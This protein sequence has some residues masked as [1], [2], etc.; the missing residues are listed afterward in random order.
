[1]RGRTGNDSLSGQF[2]ADTATFSLSA[3]AVNVN[4][5]TNVA[6]GEGSDILNTAENVVG[7]PRNDTLVGNSGAN[8][9]DGLAGNDRIDARAGNDT[10][11]GG[12]HTDRCNGGTGI[13]VASR[14]ET[15]VSIP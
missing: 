1:L 7:S 15:L 13:D 2:G 12:V 4:L 8:R 3:A 9:L 10:L 11:I 14:C 6:S 5:A